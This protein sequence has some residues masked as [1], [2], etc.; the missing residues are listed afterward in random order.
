MH[1][2][3]PRP[4][5]VLAPVPLL[6]RHDQAVARQ[7]PVVPSPAPAP[8][9][10]PGPPTRRP[11]AGHPTAS[12]RG[13]ARTATPQPRRPSA[14]GWSAAAATGQ[15]ARRP[16]LSRSYRAF[17]PYTD[18][19]EAPYRA[20]TS[21]TGDPLRTSSTACRRCSPSHLLPSEDSSRSPATKAINDRRSQD[22]PRTT[23]QKCRET[24]HDTRMP[25]RTVAVE[26]TCGARVAAVIWDVRAC[27]QDGRPGR[28]IGC[29]VMS[30]RSARRAQDCWPAAPPTSSADERMLILWPEVGA[31]S[32]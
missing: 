21:A 31:S 15:P 5:P 27:G 25:S 3:F 8:A 17:Q 9:R 14:A 29:S 32:V 22:V 30:R 24:S 16:R 20:A 2:C 19:R 10:P 13:A 7:R 6:L 26:P 11:A 18:C 23:C 28:E 1:R 4:A 12:G